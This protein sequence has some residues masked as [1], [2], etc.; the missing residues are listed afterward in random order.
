[1]ENENTYYPAK[2]NSHENTTINLKN[3]LITKHGGNYI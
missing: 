3:S 2:S 1:M